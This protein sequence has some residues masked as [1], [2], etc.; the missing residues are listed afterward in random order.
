MTLKDINPQKVIESVRQQMAADAHLP[1]GFAAAIDLLIMLCVLLVERLPKNSKNSS[2]PP[3]QDPN[4]LKKSRAQNKRKAGAQS[5]HV[6]TTLQAVQEPDRIEVIAVDRDTIPKGVWKECGYERRQVFDI[7]F[8]FEVIEYRAQ[9]LVNEIGQKVRADFPD[10]VTSRTQYG[11]AVKAASVYYSQFQLLPYERIAALFGDQFS[12]PISVGTLFNFNQEAYRRLD[13]FERW[14]RLQLIG[15]PVLNLDETSINVNG[16]KIWLHLASTPLYTFYFPHQKRGLAAIAEMD[17]LPHSQGIFCHD[18]WMAYFNYANEHALCNAHILR[19]LFAAYHDDRQIW[20]AKMSSLLRHINRLTQ[21]AGGVLADREIKKWRQ[22]YKRILALGQTQCPEAQRP[23]GQKGRLKKSKSRNLLERL[24]EYENEVLRF[25]SNPL[26][27]FT[28]NLAENDL[29]MTKVQQKI[30]GCF[31]SFEGAE[32]F[33]RIR[34]Y[35]STCRK[36]NYS[37]H[38]ALELL[39]NGKL[40][41]FIKIQKQTAE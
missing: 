1:P 28:N 39:F 16:Q 23:P 38:L 24:A 7:I 17:I 22:H 10:E 11:G 9:I 13:D 12:L 20:A 8:D 4:R 2:L 5:G 32:I 36:N 14:L 34:S 40:P 35:L 27:P 26:V 30:S 18:H 33:C 41:C 19:E 25:M 31:R 15:A 21:D 3:S 29:R 6:G 37:P